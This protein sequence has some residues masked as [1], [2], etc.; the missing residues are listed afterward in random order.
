MTKS[1][2][3]R[4][5]EIVRDLAGMNRELGQ[6]EYAGGCD[7]SNPLT[8]RLGGALLWVPDDVFSFFKHACVSYLKR[9]IKDL[10]AE[11]SKL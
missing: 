5:S 10:E 1:Q 3:D 4:A 2:Y 9:K 11:F 6:W 8:L 7:V